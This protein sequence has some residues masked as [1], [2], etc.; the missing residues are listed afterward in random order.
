MNCEQVIN[1]LDDFVD[2]YLASGETRAIEDHLVVCDGCNEVVGRERKF[3]L[4]LGSIPAQ[5]PE[6]GFVEQA[7]A[8]ATG[9]G[10]YKSGWWVGFS[11]GGG[12][13]VAVL[14]LFFLGLPFQ[15]KDTG[16]QQLAGVNMTI[17]E[18]KNVQL[19]VNVAQNLEGSI[20]TIML[21]EHVEIDGLPGEREITW[22]ADLKKGKNL[23]A[24]PVVA[25]QLGAAP[26]VA[27]VEHDNKRKIFEVNLEVAG[28]ESP[29]QGHLVGSW[30]IG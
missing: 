22:T 19:V 8:S 10:G 1:K 11:A 12:L 24:L 9:R 20:I 23:L 18:V 14:L 3:R 7:F 13:A 15:G 4:A 17:N 5:Q 6:A 29:L 16:L 27:R 2:G 21:P 30:D 25:R 28:G 26:L